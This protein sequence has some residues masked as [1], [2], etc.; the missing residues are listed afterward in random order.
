MIRFA[1]NA[2][3]AGVLCLLSAVIPA[4]SHK[5][6]APPPPSPQ[7]SFELPFASS[8]EG[9]LDDIW[10]KTWYWT[11]RAQL[12]A[13]SLAWSLDTT[14]ASSGKQSI[15]TPP[16]SAMEWGVYCAEKTCFCGNILRT[17]KPIDLSRVT[18]A[19]LR[20]RNVRRV[21]Q[22]VTPPSCWSSYDCTGG[23][24]I[25]FKVGWINEDQS[26]ALTQEAWNQLATFSDATDWREEVVD[27]A[28]VV[29]KKVYLGFWQVDHCVR[30]DSTS[31]STSWKIDDVLVN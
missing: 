14:S 7:T 10:L 15:W 22:S 17:A 20:F 24:T 28:A 16:L 5:P 21:I 11:Q 30:W 26:A 25:A 6:T 18:A 29:G 19:T 12:A 3:P 8:F 13:I 2:L 27:L 4:C 23:S 1:N 31:T 9:N